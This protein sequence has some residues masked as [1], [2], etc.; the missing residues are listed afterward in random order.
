MLDLSFAK[1]VARLTTIAGSTLLFS[2]ATIDAETQ[3]P[4]P[5]KFAPA[6]LTRP[7][8]PTGE[9]VDPS[10]ASAMTLEELLVFADSES[11][12]IQT[13][14]ARMGI[15]DAQVSGAKILFPDNPELSFGVGQRRAAGASAF[16]FEASIQQRLEIAGEPGLRL[17]A[18]RDQ[19]KLREADV[20]EVR[21]SVHVE[22]HRLFVDILLVRERLEQAE[23][24]VEFAESMR[25]IAARQVEAGESSPLILLVAEADL[26]QTREA[27]I[28]ARRSLEGL[29][30]RLAAVIGWPQLE[31]PPVEGTLPPL[32]AAPNPSDLLTLMAEHHPELRT[33]ELAVL[34]EQ[35]RLALEHREAWPEPT[36]GLSFGREAALGPEAGT[37]LWLINMSLPLPFWRRNQEGR[38]LAQARLQIADSERAA[39]AARLRAELTEAAIAMNAAAE[40]VTLYETSVVPQLEENLALLQRAFELGEVDVHQVSQTR[41]R[42]LNATGQYIDARI[43]Y[44]ESAAMLEG[45]VGTEIW[46]NDTE[47]TP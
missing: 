15:A 37:N 36:L 35:S 10:A 25:D 5:G 34:A 1:K 40:R 13:V 43:T 47:N 41:E 19:Q 29:T 7:Y 20:Q 45:L 26:A 38:A 27:V 30:T 18:A 2:C 32:R 14:L 17:D 21:W 39:T 46:T 28:E 22:V 33:R 8:V 44:Y 9:P 12:A 3:L 11:P 31:L 24:F 4:E 16:E 23:R 42:L 6:E